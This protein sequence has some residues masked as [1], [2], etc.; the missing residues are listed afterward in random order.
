MAKRN[1]FTFN[2]FKIAGVSPNDLTASQRKSVIKEVKDFVIEEV[3]TRVGG[4]QSTA[5]GEKSFK[6]LSKDYAKAQK[7]GNRKPNLELTGDML[8]SLTVKQD[9]NKLTLSVSK[10]ENNKAEGHN[11]LGS[12]SSPL[13]R[14]R[15]I[16]AQ[17]QGFKKEINAEI[18]SIVNDEVDDGE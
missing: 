6:I 16:P 14:R 17:K 2:P 12:K 5:K 1:S 7:G 9:G 10:T 8:D 15:F 18:A 4:G 13:P 3:L 11:Q